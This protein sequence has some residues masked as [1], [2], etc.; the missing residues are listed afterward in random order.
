MKKSKEADVIYIISWTFD[1][2]RYSIEK[3]ESDRDKPMKYLLGLQAQTDYVWSIEC[4][5][6]K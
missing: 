2:Q 4:I 1:G 3:S 6:K 5:R